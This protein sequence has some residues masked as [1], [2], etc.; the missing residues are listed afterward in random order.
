[1]LSTLN[2]VLPAARARGVCLPAIDIAGGQPDF[3]LGVLRTCEKARCPAVMLVWA[4]A[5]YI[6]LEACADLVSHYAARSP[7][8]VVLH[9]DHGKEDQVERAL[10]AGLKSVM[11]DGSADPL[12]LNIERTR[13]M[14]A[15]A[16]E[17][18]ASIEGEVGRFG[19]EMGANATAGTL[20]DPEQAATFVRE[21]GVDL[22]APSV[23][24]A[25][26]FTKE[27]PKLHF[28]L[29]E[30]IARKTGVPLSLHGG[31]GIPL[32]DVHRAGT[33]GMG[34]INVA[35][36]IH[37]D[38]ADALKACVQEDT[39]AQYRME[40]DPGRRPAGHQRPD[41]GVRRRA[42]R[43][44]ARRMSDGRAKKVVGVGLACLDQL[45]RWKDAALPVH[46]NRV[47]DYEVQG[48]GLVGTALSAVTR[49]GGRAEWWG[50]VG[51]D[52]M[53]R[54]VLDSLVAEGIDVS[55]AR[56]VE[57]G[58][59]PMVLVC[60]DGATGE[61]HFLYAVGLRGDKPLVGEHERL[62][63][64]GC[65]LVDQWM[66]ESAVPAAD[67]ARRLGVPVVADCQW[68]TGE[69]VRDL[70]AH[71]D[72]AILGEG[73]ALQQEVGDDMRRACEIIRE[74]GPHHVVITL[75]PRGLVSMEGDRFRELPSYSV[76][77]VDTTGAGDVFHGAFCRGLVLGLSTEDNLRFAS[78]TAS[79]KCRRLGGR[80]G[81]PTFDE[82]VAFLRDHG[83]ELG[84]A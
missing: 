59:G 2:D 67:E 74:M 61:R 38:Y 79:L 24:N 50:A 13:K 57:D 25:H 44:G 75:G 72:H 15:M 41:T 31:T 17:Y 71:V 34:K 78:A 51:G 6:G 80:A 66:E 22:L 73:R 30:E 16:R 83:V 65:L 7:V 42:R 11:F 84:R 14:V 32:A 40:Q 62:R 36:Q 8:P 49:L 64:A 23:G 45:I 10:K 9:L 37:R 1:M 70:L 43:E 12:E 4:G 46:E 20:T 29:I 63:E 55:Q 81:I 68:G 39:A 53:G 19:R 56:V 77:V 60:V 21:T 5:A 26:G 58:R 3:L 69:R 28:D 47:I 18:G 54:M 33:L 35:S 27:V 52:W 76:D 48:G 82:V